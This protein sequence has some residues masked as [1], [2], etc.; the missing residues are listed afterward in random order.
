MDR[1]RVGLIGANPRR[2]WASLSHI[3]ALKA[4]PGFQLTA[5]A[6]SSEASAQEAAAAFQ[7]PEAFSSAAQ[8]IHSHSVDLVSVCVKV[9]YHCELVTA[10]LAAGKH[11]L[12]EWPLALS[13]R[14]AEDM[15]QLAAT[16]GVRANVGLQA[17]INPA[18][19][20]A[21]DLIMDGSIGVPLTAHVLSTTEGHGVAL[22][23]AYAYLC[24]PANGATMSTILTGHTLDLAIYLLGGIENLQAMTTTKFPEVQLTDVGGHVPRL[25][26]DS[27]AIQAR[28]T[29]G[30]LFSAEIDGGRPADTPFVFQVI[31]TKGSLSLRGGHPYGFQAGEIALDATIKFKAPDLPA[32]PQLRGSLLNVGEQYARFALDLQRNQHTVP[33]F[34]HAVQL[35]QLIRSVG[36]AAETGIRQD[37]GNWPTA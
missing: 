19:R 6:T 24:D 29:N 31:G 32:A 26:A 11:V 36:V 4:L 35:H 23:S 15:R 37:A 9:P 17:R 34:F 27:L 5:V 25:T 7:I 10:A 33:D 22:P 8:L 16:A 30:C 2:S 1:I 3:P 13:V 14:E 12:C 21:H 20:R 18:V 28:F